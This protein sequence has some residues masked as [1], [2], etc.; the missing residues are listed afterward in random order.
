MDSQ[1]I[2]GISVFGDGGVLGGGV[3]VGDGGWRCQVCGKVNMGICSC[4]LDRCD[5]FPSDT[6]DTPLPCTILSS[7]SLFCDSYHKWPEHTSTF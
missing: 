4:L 2:T 5:F 1:V 6:P 3:K 7:K